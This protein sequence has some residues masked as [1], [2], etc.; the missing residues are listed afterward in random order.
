MRRAGGS[1]VEHSEQPHRQLLSVWRDTVPAKEHALAD[2]MAT[3]GKDRDAAV[4]DHRQGEGPRNAV[5]NR[6]P[7]QERAQLRPLLLLPAFVRGLAEQKRPRP[8][9]EGPQ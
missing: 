8:L 6:Y 5:L 7:A 2:L 1:T 9:D 3:L 4:A